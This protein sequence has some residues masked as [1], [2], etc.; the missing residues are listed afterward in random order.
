MRTVCYKEVSLKKIIGFVGC[1]SHDVILMLTGVLGCMGKKVLLRDRNKLH[2]LSVSVPV[3]EGVCA[4]ETVMEY[5]GFFFTEREANQEETEEY[6]IELVDF[7][8]EWKPEAACCSELVVITDMLLHHIRRLNEIDIPK[9]RV[10]FCIMR[11]SFASVCKGEQEVEL[12]LRSFP[13][14]IECFLEPDCRDVKNRYVCESLHEYSVSKASP[15]MQEIIG[16]M[17]G[18]LCTEYSER[19]IRRCIKYRG[20]RRYR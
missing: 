10:R 14:A 4:A 6:E 11:D 13:N 19:E 16:R 12:F 5:D 2:T 17:A 8:M 1:Y 15:E 7:G 9:E 3:P 18:F 20:R